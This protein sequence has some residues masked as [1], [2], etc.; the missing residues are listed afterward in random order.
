ME[1]KYEPAQTRNYGPVEKIMREDQTLSGLLSILNANFV[2]AKNLDTVFREC[3]GEE[4]AS[5]NSEKREIK[6]CYEF[7][8]HLAKVALRGSKK[9]ADALMDNSLEFFFAR[10]VGKALVDIDQLPAVGDK[11][12]SVAEDDAADEFAT[13]VMLRLFEGGAKKLRDAAEGISDHYKHKTLDDELAEIRASN[14]LCWTYGADPADMETHK[15]ARRARLPES[16]LDGCWK[17]YRQI[18]DTW[19]RRLGRHLKQP[20]TITPAAP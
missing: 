20:G 16:R 9:H 19:L 7:I 18:G 11:G 12:N 1:V 4:T 15:S 14:I 13:F 17:E 2:L 3:N 5:Y 10:E 8:A 6:I